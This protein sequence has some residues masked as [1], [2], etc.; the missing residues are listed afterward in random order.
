MVVKVDRKV[1]KN[2]ILLLALILEVGIKERK[3][4]VEYFAPDAVTEL[5]AWV[6]DCLERGQFRE[7]NER[8]IGL[9]KD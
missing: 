9:I 7:L 5:R 8:L 1:S 4:L 3:A 6:D 2:Q